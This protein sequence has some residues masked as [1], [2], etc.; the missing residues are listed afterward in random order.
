MLEKFVVELKQQMGEGLPGREAQMLMAPRR[1]GQLQ[2]SFNHLSPPRESAVLILFYPQDGQIHFPLMVRPTYRGV[3]SGQISF[4]G[5]KF[6]VEDSTL[7]NT[8]LREA[9]EEIGIDRSQVEV[10]GQLSSHY[11]PPSNFNIEPYLA[12]TT[13]KPRFV[14]EEKEVEEIL[15][16]A[17]NDIL[18][19]KLRK[20][21]RLTPYNGVEIETP[22]FDI[23]DRVVWGATAM[24]LSE[25]AE[26]IKQTSYNP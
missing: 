16:V 21:T 23:Q 17:L 8:A 2:R 4:P 19:Q 6:E 3:H 5:G 25:L 10:F 18:D 12:F 9:E 1:M 11:I 15:E 14:R 24:I 26:I 7:Q 22:Y 13:D 20:Q